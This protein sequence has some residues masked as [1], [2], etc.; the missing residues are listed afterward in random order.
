MLRE[1]FL[2]GEFRRVRFAWLGLV[3]F[4]CHALFKAWLKWALNDWYARFYDGLQD[5][6][7]VGS[8]EVDSEQ[9]HLA[10]KRA[11]VSNN[12]MEFAF[13]VAPAV[14]VHPIAKW[15]AS[16]WRFAWRV[17]LVRSYLAHY[18]VSA[19]PI[20]GTAQ[21]IHEDTLRF[22]S[23]VYT[24]FTIVLDSFLTLFIFV[25]VLLDVGSRAMP[26]G[27]D[28]APWLLSI[29]IGAALGGLIVS[30]GVGYKLVGLEVENQKVEAKLRTKLVM[31]EESP[32]VVVGA[33][34]AHAPS[35]PDEMVTGNELSDGVLP[36]PRPC[37]VAPTNAF[38]VVLQELWCNYKRL[39]ANFAAF[40]TWIALFD[41]TMLILPY[42][43]VA[44]LMFA[45]D[46]AHRITLG[47]LMKV[48]NAFDKVFGA[49]AVVSENWASVND[50]RSTVWRLREFEQ[51]IYSRK[52]FSARNVYSEL[53]ERTSTIERVVREIS[54]R[55]TPL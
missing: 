22:E 29:A 45:E 13:I 46:P 12:L 43:L 16:V 6:A 9:E 52:R 50:F 23:G 17:A 4:V 3:T 15:V 10:A 51:A 54:L 31:L 44:P 49:M 40:N 53:A 41:Q 33:V 28:W 38:Q 27:V 47:T 24:C 39:F 26:P 32:V 18:D 5:V 1:F 11:E 21:R 35:D 55:S 2:A 42:L 19:A 7:S 34:P 36:N 25:P 14:V 48:A 30:M 20:E 37:D 8:G